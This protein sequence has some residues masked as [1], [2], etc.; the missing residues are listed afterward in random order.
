LQQLLQLLDISNNFT[1]IINNNN[2]K[3]KWYLNL[4]NFSIL[5]VLQIHI[6]MTIREKSILIIAEIQLKKSYLKLSINVVERNASIKYEMILNSIT[7]R[8]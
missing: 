1:Q 3:L 6:F 2:N 7:F 5:Y 8:K 4:K